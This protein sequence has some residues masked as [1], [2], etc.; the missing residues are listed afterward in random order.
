[1]N[2]PRICIQF[3]F[4]QSVNTVSLQSVSKWKR[5]TSMSNIQG[6]DEMNKDQLTIHWLLK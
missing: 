6:D 1:M 5:F 4:L 3:A 2:D